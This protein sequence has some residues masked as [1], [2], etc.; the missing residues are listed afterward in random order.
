MTKTMELAP[1]AASVR[2]ARLFTA[3]VLGDDGV[4]SSVIELAVLLVSELVTNAAVHARSGVR[5]TVH[6]DSHWVRIEVEDEGPGEPV[7]GTLTPNQLKGR[8]LAVVD[9]L[10]TDWGADMHDDHKVVWFE[11]AR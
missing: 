7:M 8:G 11:I 4:E 1:K 3:D 5:M 6:V 2:T 10:S 9:R